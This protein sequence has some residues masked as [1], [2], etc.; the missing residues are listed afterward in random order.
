MHHRTI[1]IFL[2]GFSGTVLSDFAKEN[3]TEVGLY[4]FVFL[5]KKICKFYLISVFTLY[6]KPTLTR[7][8]TVTPFDASGKQA[9]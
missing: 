9:F 2:L 1:K 8:H 7:S 4:G 3:W 5:K 6:Q